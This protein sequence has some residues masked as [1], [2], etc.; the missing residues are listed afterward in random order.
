MATESN[1]VQPA[2][3][4]LDAYYGH[5]CML[6]ENFLLEGI[7]KPDRTS[8]P[9]SKNRGKTHWKTKEDD[10]RCKTEGFES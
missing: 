1:F 4:K 5:W 9:Y 8:D 10:W 3:P 2:I 7:L 6:I